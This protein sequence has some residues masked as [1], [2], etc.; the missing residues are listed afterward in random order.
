MGKSIGVYEF[1]SILD[2]PKRK[3]N[4]HWMSNGRFLDNSVDHRLDLIEIVKP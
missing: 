4:R 2:E 3:G 1:E